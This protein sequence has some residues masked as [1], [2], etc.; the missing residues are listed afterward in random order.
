MQYFLTYNLGLPQPSGKKAEIGTIVHKVLEG[1]ALCKLAEQDGGGDIV[2]NRILGDLEVQYMNDPAYVSL[3]VQRSYDYYVPNSVHK[4]YPRDRK[5]CDTLTVKALEQGS[6][7]F[8]PRKR[9]IVAAEPFFDF[10]I[11]EDWA[12]YEETLPNGDTISGQL[13]LRGTVDLVLDCGNSMYEVNDWKTGQRKDWATGEEKDYWKLD[14]DPQLSIYHLALSR[15]YPDIPR[16][17]MTMN[18]ID[19]GG[20]FTCA[21]DDQDKIRT[22]EMLRTQFERIKKC[23]RPLLRRGKDRWFCNRVCH[24]GKTEHPDTTCNDS[25]C[26]HIHQKL[27]RKGMFKTMQEETFPGFVIGTYESPGE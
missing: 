7:M 5:K 15:K 1:L 14:K 19:Y 23:T 8:D 25:V 16:W 22:L 9:N 27:L 17:A 13:A 4:W 18:Y 20:P 6:G 26:W 21:Y 11:E 2:P 12:H 10:D 3:L 24:Y